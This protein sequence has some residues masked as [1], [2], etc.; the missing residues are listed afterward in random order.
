MSLT[1]QD[2]RK[3]NM[4]ECFTS[5]SFSSPQ[6]CQHG[7]AQHLEHLL[8]YGAD[9]TSQDASGNTALHIC[10][11]YNKVQQTLTLNYQGQL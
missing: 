9:T 3:V 10:A 6:A 4:H 8:F 11:L 5:H 1:K 7:F 2:E